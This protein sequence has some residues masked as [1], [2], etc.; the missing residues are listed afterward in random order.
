MSTPQLEK[1]K[2]IL[3]EPPR[4]AIVIFNDDF[5]PMEFVIAV[6]VEIIGIGSDE[7]AV[8]TQTVHTSGK[9]T[10][11]SFTRDIAESKAAL[12]VQ[13]AQEHEFPLKALPIEL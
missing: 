7:A 6:L 4:Y 13:L 1:E 12:I 3:A 10:C 5:T 11:G 9:A 2:Q 8:I